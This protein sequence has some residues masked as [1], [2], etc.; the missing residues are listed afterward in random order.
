M[1]GLLLA[2]VRLPDGAPA[3]A[4]R[5]AGLSLLERALFVARDAGVTSAIVAADRSLHAA[6]RSAVR[7]K[8]L[9]VE[10]D[11]ADPA[12]DRDRIREKLAGGGPVAVL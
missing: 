1:Q 2:G 5:V 4:L 7:R 6:L 10:L 8:D 3:A 9:G 11:F 12:A